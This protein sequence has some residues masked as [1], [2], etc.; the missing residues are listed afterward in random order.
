VCYC[1]RQWKL[2]TGAKVYPQHWDKKKQRC[3][4]GVGLTKLENRNNQ[5]ANNKLRS[6]LFCEQEIK[7]YLCEVDIEDIDNDAFYSM[8]KQYINPKME[9]RNMKKNNQ[10][11]ATLLME[12]EIDNCGAKDSTKGTYKARLK[13]FDNFLLESKK[14]DRLS[15]INKLLMEKYIDWCLDKENAPNTIKEKFNT[16]VV[17]MKSI[18][19]NNDY[20]FKYE[21]TGI[22]KIDIEGRCKD[23]RTPK[24]IANNRIWLNE[25]EVELIYQLHLEGEREEIRDLFVL[26]CYTAQRISDMPKFINKE[27][28]ITKN[29]ETI[30][31]VQKKTDNEA[32]IPLK[33]IPKVKELLLKYSNGFSYL[34]MPKSNREEATFR[35]K[36]NDELKIIAK[37]AG[38]TRQYEY[39]YPKINGMRDKGMEIR[40]ICDY[41]HTHVGRH[42][43]ITYLKRKGIQ[44]ERIKKI[45]GHSDTKIIESIYSH[46]SSEEEADLLAKGI[47]DDLRKNDKQEVKVD[48]INRKE[49]ELNK[50]DNIEREEAIR[51]MRLCL[52]TFTTNED[53]I[54]YLK[55]NMP[56]NDSGYFTYAKEIKDLFVEQDWDYSFLG[57]RVLNI[58]AYERKQLQVIF[59]RVYDSE[60]PIFDQKSRDEV[61]AILRGKSGEEQLEIYIDYTI[62]TAPFWVEHRKKIVEELK[63][64][65]SDIQRK[66]C[67]GVHK[68]KVLNSVDRL[69]YIRLYNSII[70]EE[71]YDIGELKD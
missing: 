16:L 4:C 61:N 10:I 65:D 71:G 51:Y 6:V 9:N 49:A 7:T 26:Q 43:G 68:K 19:K 60:E 41:I 31:I 17:L 1:G 40:N 29:G 47:D 69:Y 28:K 18:S 48:S 56:L 67:L 36:I 25:E 30:I 3:V 8:L 23:L 35:N 44:L 57:F 21:D 59:K 38:I 42:T 13:D 24:E 53:R 52:P 63:A 34:K 27:Y 46:T 64:L 22:D 54:R 20:N 66:E 55:Q 58:S 39:T 33:Y 50:A 45:S 70:A 32:L 14:Q 62:H 37:E 11:A 5:I 12:Q 15:S 2:N